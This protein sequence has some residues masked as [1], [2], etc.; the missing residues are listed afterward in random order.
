MESV[1]LTRIYLQ[2][3]LPVWNEHPSNHAGLPWCLPA[4][5]RGYHSMRWP[6]TDLKIRG[7]IFTHVTEPDMREQT[8][9]TIQKIS[10]AD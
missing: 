10:K 6:V 5:C 2:D 7:K 8:E 9:G 4:Q 3:L 1:S